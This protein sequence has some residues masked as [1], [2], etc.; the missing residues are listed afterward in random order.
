MDNFCYI[1]GKA[2]NP[3]DSYVYIKNPLLSESEIKNFVY[4]KDT[5]ETTDETETTN[6]TETSNK[7]TELKKILYIDT[8][9]IG[10]FINFGYKGSDTSFSLNFRKFV[11]S[12][13]NHFTNIASRISDLQ[14]LQDN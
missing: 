5:D 2:I 4:N 8:I 7:I 3:S 14:D 12:L 9:H 6:E 10:Q 13:S 11:E 1:K